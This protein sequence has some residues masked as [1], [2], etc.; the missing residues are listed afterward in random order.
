MKLNQ[1]KA[2]TILTYLTMGLGYIISLAYTP[3]MIRLLGKSEYGLY[4][5]VASVVAYLG[6]LSFGFGSA[7]V[8]YYVPLK[9]ENKRDEI[10][11]L[12][13]MFLSIFLF[14]ALLAVLAGG[15]MA[16]N[17]RLVFG[18]KLTAAEL[19]TARV[20]LIILVINLAIS[21]PGIV[22]TSYITANERFF[23][24]KTIHL[25][26]I[27]TSPLVTLPAL[28][29]GYGSVGYIIGTTLVNL[30]VE[31]AHIIYCFRKLG[32]RIALGH[33][34]RILFKSL[35]VFS[36]YIFINMVTDQINWNLGKYVLGR[37][38]GTESVAVFGL[39]AQL[40]TYYISI[41]T[42]VSNVFIPRVHKMVA[43]GSSGA[44]LTGIFTRIGRIQF[45]VLMLVSSFFV[46]YARPFFQLWAGPGYAGSVS[47]LLLLS[48]PVTIPLIQNI[49]IE[50]QRA[51]DQH[52]FRSITYAFIA[53]LN[54]PLTLYLAKPLAGLGAALGTAIA[55]LIGNG[56]LMNW[57][58]HARIGLDIK[59]FWKEIISLLPAL[60]PVAVIGILAPRLVNLYK[61]VWLM[62]ALA[63]HVLAYGLG[64]WFIGMNES[65]KDLI[66]KP[67][68]RLMAA[69]SRRRK[70]T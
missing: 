52:R 68:A 7:Y 25:L 43:Q 19:E 20:L 38:H 21:F 46:F 55:L 28:L 65:E 2:G 59:R 70:R 57:Y 34:D 6:I 11:K 30:A 23:F 4:N 37:Y 48:L 44:Q 64:M 9:Q 29:M 40:N 36:T 42:A 63:A 61:P 51:M 15:V 8:R 45:M 47:I 31:L 67:Y 22:F 26:K 14:V 33:F 69:V 24:Q 41:S 53:V 49:G 35:T 56:F 60:L 16:A 50:I 32:M 62:L 66:R 39:A 1:L 12:N 58:Y 17:A 27:I 13:G 18:S 3:L 10:A 54:L 5:L